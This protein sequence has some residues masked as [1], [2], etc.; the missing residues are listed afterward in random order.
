[1]RDGSVRILSANV[2]SGIWVSWEDILGRSTLDDVTAADFGFVYACGAVEPAGALALDFTAPQPG[3]TGTYKGLAL[4]R[5]GFARCLSYAQAC[6]RH[7]QR[8]DEVIVREQALHRA[9]GTAWDIIDLWGQL[10]LPRG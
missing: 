2:S 4:L 3:A 9:A 1:M 7:D 8:G 5:F 10:R 6:A